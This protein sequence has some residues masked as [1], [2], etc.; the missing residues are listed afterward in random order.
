MI[1]LRT[2]NIQYYIVLY[3]FFGVLKFRNLGITEYTPFIDRTYKV[4][5]QDPVDS[6]RLS[7]SER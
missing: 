5:I 7:R 4:G 3:I 6:L 2:I 1:R